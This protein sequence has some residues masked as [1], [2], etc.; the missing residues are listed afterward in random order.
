MQYLNFLLEVEKYSK[1]SD[2]NEKYMSTT[3]IIYE[4]LE[5]CHQWSTLLP[6]FCAGTLLLP[7]TSPWFYRWKGKKKENCISIVIQSWFLGEAL[8]IK[9]TYY[10]YK[11]LYKA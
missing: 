9:I 5:T 2:Q 8:G 6:V 1:N 3:I 11:G 7:S 4:S 10:A